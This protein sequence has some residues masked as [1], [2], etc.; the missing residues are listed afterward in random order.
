MGLFKM[1]KKNEKGFTLVELLVVI[2]I[3]GILAAVIAPN[4]FAQIERGKISAVVSEY[5]AVKTAAILVDSDGKSITDDQGLTLVNDLLEKK[6][7]GTGAT[8]APFGGNYKIVN[9]FLI[10]PDVPVKAGNS[11]AKTIANLDKP[12]FTG[13]NENADVRWVSNTT[14]N[15]DAIAEPTGEAATL[16]IRLIQ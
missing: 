9:N 12:G 3:I 8:E 16:A 7:F 11:I 10:V 2:A 4:V 5:R 14:T 1:G 6:M 15:A 13:T